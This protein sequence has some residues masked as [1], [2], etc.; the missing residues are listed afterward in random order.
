MQKEET[1]KEIE[2]LRQKI[3]HHDYLYYVLSQPEIS[4]KEYDDL[5][6]KL[7]ELEEKYPEFKTID[8]PTVRISGGVSEGFKTVKH[9]QK[10]LSIDN[11]YSFEELK[12][13]DERVH[14][15][16]PRA[17][18]EYVAEL[19]IDGLSANITYEKGRLIIAATRGDGETG[20]DVTQNIKT[21]RAIPLVLMVDEIPDFVV[22]RHYKLWKD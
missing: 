16:L 4:D 15:G 20:E 8:S 3:H 12:E 22:R 13:W 17:K 9:K 10:M 1:R 11:T 2:R 19:K 14:K 5:L 7:K 18:A 6:R 21:I